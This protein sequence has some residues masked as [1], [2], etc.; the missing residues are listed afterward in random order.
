[1]LLF[2]IKHLRLSTCD[3]S[4][5][6]I[7]KSIL[8]H[9]GSSPH[10]HYYQNRLQHQ[11]ISCSEHNSNCS[12]GQQSQIHLHMEQSWLNCQFFKTF[13][14]LL[15]ETCDLETW[16]ITD[17]GTAVI[18]FLCYNFKPEIPFFQVNSFIK[19]VPVKNFLLVARR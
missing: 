6:F 7:R 17:R 1:M 19:D 2:V 15:Q 8:D 9:G 5:I 13:F 4:T 12:H 18:L 3:Q 10:F 11:E 16:S 14:K